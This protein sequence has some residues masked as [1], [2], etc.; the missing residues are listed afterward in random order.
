MSKVMAQHPRGRLV[1]GTVYHVPF[2]V[3]MF[4]VLNT[5]KLTG[6]MHKK[7]THT[8]MFIKMFI[9]WIVERVCSGRC[10]HLSMGF[11]LLLL[12]VEKSQT[13]TWYVEKPCK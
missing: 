10:F 1:R 8:N 13:T 6:Q 3:V 5:Q 7:N 2:Q 9:S 11:S 4:V 12:M